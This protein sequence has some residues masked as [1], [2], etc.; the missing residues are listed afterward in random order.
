MEKIKH[1]DIK[2]IFKN[3]GAIEY[4]EV[5][6]N[7]LTMIVGKN[8]TSK[9]YLTYIIWGFLDFIRKNPFLY[10]QLFRK[11]NSLVLDCYSYCYYLCYCLCYCY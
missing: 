11:F 5:P 4:A 1:N 6:L 7:D 8:S 9:T 2:F 10:N 3:I